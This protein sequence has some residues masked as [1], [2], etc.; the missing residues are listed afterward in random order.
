MKQ[1]SGEAQLLAMAML[2]CFVGFLAGLPRELAR[3]PDEARLQAAGWLF[4]GAMFFGPLFLIGLAALSHLLARPFGGR[5]NWQ[6][7]RLALFWALV[8]AIPLL[9]VAE[10]GPWW[11]GLASMIA[12]GWIW[13]ETLSEA[14]EF[15]QS[16]KVFLAVVAPV[17]LIALSL[18]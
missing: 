8:L 5:A 7:A 6:Q 15:S 1:L 11:V 18:A 12:T 10:F 9:I 4:T 14:E 17:T 3:V 16:W 13:A 2:V